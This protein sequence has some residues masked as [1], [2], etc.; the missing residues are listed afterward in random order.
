VGAGVLGSVLSRED[1]VPDVD[2]FQFMFGIVAAM[3]VMA[4]LA[5]L[6]IER[7]P[8]RRAESPREGVE[9]IAV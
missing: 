4:F 3:A 8:G 1:A 9:A 5:T 2:V 6:F 7:F